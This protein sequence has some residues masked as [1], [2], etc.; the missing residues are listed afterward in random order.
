MRVGNQ[1]ML[2]P[3]TMVGKYP[4]PRWWKG[5]AFAKYPGQPGRAVF[6]SMSEE[7]FEDCLQCMTRDQERAGLDIIAD[8]RVFDGEDAYG[9][10]LYHY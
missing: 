3:T 4:E 5:Q 2:L 9:Q 10:L 6:D 7:A 1:E 8:G